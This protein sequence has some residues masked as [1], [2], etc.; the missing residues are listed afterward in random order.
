MKRSVMGAI[1]CLVSLSAMAGTS[2]RYEPGDKEAHLTLDNAITADA[3]FLFDLLKVEATFTEHG[4]VSKALVSALNEMLIVCARKIAS[5]NDTSC[6]VA[7]YGNS[8]FISISK[9]L[10][11][12][13]ASFYGRVYD[14]LKA[15]IPDAEPPLYRSPDSRFVILKNIGASLKEIWFTW[16]EKPSP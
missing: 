15:A 13:V 14:P 16:S 5:P 6:E 9:E 12:V 4:Y 11:S 8:P 7:F 10:G 3:D 2:M 1:V